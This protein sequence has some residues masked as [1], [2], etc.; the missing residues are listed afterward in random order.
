MREEEACA[1]SATGAYLLVM[2]VAFYTGT[3]EVDGGAAANELLMQMQADLLGSTVTRPTHLETT[4]LG[5]T[6]SGMETTVW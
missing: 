5:A 4:A 3:A 1:M 6:A 2:T